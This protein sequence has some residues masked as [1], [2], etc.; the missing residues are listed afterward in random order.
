M[1]EQNSAKLAI[2]IVS[3]RSGVTAETMSHTL[4]SQFRGISVE[5]ISCPFIDTHEKVNKVKTNIQEKYV[6]SGL[7]PLVFTT[8]AEDA[9]GDVFADLPAHIFNFFDPFISRLEEILNQPALHKPGLAHGISDAQK[10]TRRIDAVHFALH[11]DDGLNM[12]EYTGADLIL[13]GVSR[14]GKTPTSLYMA[15][16]YGLNVANYPI[17]DEDFSNGNLP[18][19]LIRHSN[20]CFGLTIDPMRLHQIRSER[21]A[22]SRYASMQQCEQDVKSAKRMYER[23]RIEYCDSTNFSIE[24]LGSTIKHKL[25][26]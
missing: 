14:S 16:H 4:M 21:R 7:K 3:D 19:K 20:K 18:E 1:S 26:L 23:N 15:L 2:F 8:F 17:T 22:G 24:E 11:C 5:R 25:N 13:L 10:Y 9:W 6:Q 12:S